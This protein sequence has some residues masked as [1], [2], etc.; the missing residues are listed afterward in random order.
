MLRALKGLV[1]RDPGIA[2]T[3]DFLAPDAISLLP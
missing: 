2:A 1:D 3:A